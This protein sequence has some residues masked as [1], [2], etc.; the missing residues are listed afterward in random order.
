[1]GI[2]VTIWAARYLDIKYGARV[3][4]FLSISLWLVGGGFAPLFMAL[5][6]FAAAS[7]IDRPLNWW[8]THLPNSLKVILRTLWPGSV[9]AYVFTFV[10]G[11]IIAIFG[12]PL[13]WF[14]SSEVT[15]SIQWGLAYIMLTLLPISILTAIA[16]DTS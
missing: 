6:A 8:R 12:Y 1:M 2:A 3:L 10:L 7:R 16:Y 9:I 4:L 13:L 5:V 15:Y 14:F 11:V